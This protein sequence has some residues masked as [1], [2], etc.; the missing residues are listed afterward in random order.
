MQW[1]VCCFKKSWAKYLLT[2]MNF[3]KCKATTKKP[4]FSVSNFEEIKSQFLM[5]IMASVTMEEIPSDMVINWDQTAIKYIPLSDWTMAQKGS[6]RVEV[7]GIDDKRQITATFAA[8][9]TGSFLLIQLVYEGK[10]TRCH[11]AVDFPEGWHITHTPN[12][13]CNEQTMIT[14]IQSV[15]VPYMTEKRRQLGLDAKHTGL[16]ILD[17][18]KGQTT[19]RVLNLLQRNNLLYVIVPPNC[20]DRLQP[21]DVSVNRVA[22]KFLRDKFENWYADNIAAQKSSGNNIEAV[23]VRLSIVKPLAAKWMIDLYDY[24][25]AHPQIIKNGFKHVGITDFLEQ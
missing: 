3:V 12:H 11:P 8:S 21:L 2:K 23:D 17:E 20:T 1:R 5:D 7:F 9:L 4:K 13:W 18:F 6:K 15:I 16:V 25:V 10:T 19:D 22:R 24:F 14:Y